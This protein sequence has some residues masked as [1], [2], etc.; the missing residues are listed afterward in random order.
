MLQVLQD[1]VFYTYIHIAIFKVFKYFKKLQDTLSFIL[2]SPPT[3]VRG[4]TGGR[5]QRLNLM[6]EF[7]T[8]QKPTV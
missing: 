6:T 3:Q 4:Q 7:H 8:E 2:S 1:K 5:I